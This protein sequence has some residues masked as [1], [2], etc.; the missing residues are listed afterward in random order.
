M[1]RHKKITILACVF[2][3]VVS[4]VACGKIKEDE[5]VTNQQESDI[6]MS[7]SA[8]SGVKGDK[9]VNSEK[10]GRASCRERV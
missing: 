3:T 1:N 10:I 8:D 2:L 4:I 9:I 5:F 7:K 6:Q